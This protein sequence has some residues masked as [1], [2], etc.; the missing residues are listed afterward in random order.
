MRKRNDVAKDTSL[1]NQFRNRACTRVLEKYDLLQ[2]TTKQ[3]WPC[4]I[5]YIIQ[6]ISMYYIFANALLHAITLKFHMHNNIII[7]S[8]VRI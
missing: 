3:P 1:V 8:H 6:S 2:G 7:S 5:K 4:E